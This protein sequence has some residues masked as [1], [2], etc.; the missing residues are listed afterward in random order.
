MSSQSTRAQA[1]I[2]IVD[3]TPD[4][5][6]L[7]S[8]MLLDQGYRVR[9]ALNGPM[10]LIAAR[11]LPPDLILLDINMPEMNGYEVCQQLKEDAQ[12]R[13][14]PIIFLSALDSVLDK[15]KAFQLGG[16]D[17]ITKPFQF[18]E[19]LARIQSQ[20]TL[21]TLQ[22]QLQ[23]QNE[24]LQKAL[25]D[26]TKAQ[27]R[28]IQQEKMIGLGQLVAG[29]SHEINNPISF[30][31]G[32]LAPARQYFYDLL[33]LIQVYQQEFP[34]RTPAIQAAMDAIDL[35]FL[36]PD[37]HKLLDSMQTGVER[38][39]SIMLAFRIFARLDRAS[40]KSINIHEG[41]NSALQ[42]LQHRLRQSGHRPEI[43]VLTQY[44]DIPLVTCYASQLNQVFLNLLNNAIDAL[45]ER[46]GTVHRLSA[47]QSHAAL[48]RQEEFTPTLWIS[49]ELTV[50][51]TVQIRIKDN[52]CGIAEAAQPHV[53]DPF[54]TTKPV[55]EGKGL[56]LTI[57]Y[58][59]V[60]EKHNGQLFCYSYPGEGAEF[61]VEIPL[62]LEEVD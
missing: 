26:L 12:T 36:V 31:S 59:I 56:G 50:A 25:D 58:E 61:I 29:M 57:S 3:D 51:R 8:N 46:W 18:E 38:I 55:G 13:T 7:L 28:L 5:I 10:A 20:L 27:A 33:H 19:V 48:D 43:Q 54:Y 1:D 42:L 2:L 53:F 47:P 35:D 15:V 23:D 30:I 52:G 32:N 22:A 37:L 21:C 14:V 49:T 39:R 62:H 16:V 9:K 45:E 6:R 60:V 40:I 11:S 44:G 34:D 4:N 24:T 41:L 17:Y